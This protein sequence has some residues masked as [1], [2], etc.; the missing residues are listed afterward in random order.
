MGSIT[1]LL[2]SIQNFL[3]MYFNHWRDLCQ[4]TYYVP[5]FIKIYLSVSL[6]LRSDTRKLHLLN[7]KFSLINKK[8]LL[9]FFAYPIL[10]TVVNSCFY[11]VS[12]PPKLLEKRGFAVALTTVARPKSVYWGLILAQENVLGVFT[13]LY[14]YL[15]A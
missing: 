15:Y 9:T 8:L 11:V 5:N 7:K 2:K 12:M 1:T 4:W 3:Y 14:T 10:C 6:L 13:K